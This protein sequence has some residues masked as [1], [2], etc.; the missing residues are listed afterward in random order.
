[1]FLTLHVLVG[2]CDFACDDGVGV[3]GGGGDACGVRCVVD[4]GTGCGDIEVV[5][6]RRAVINPN[7]VEFQRSS[8]A[9]VRSL[10]PRP[11]DLVSS[12]CDIMFVIGH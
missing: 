12:Q 9:A 5:L 6:H 10:S 7:V 11:L 1:M 8:E 2:V 3:G 4:V